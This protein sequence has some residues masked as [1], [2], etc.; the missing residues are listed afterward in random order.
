MVMLPILVHMLLAGNKHVKEEGDNNHSYSDHYINVSN[1]WNAMKL[2]A[3]KVVAK[4][5]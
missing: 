2:V 1:V 3:M 5:H 4:L